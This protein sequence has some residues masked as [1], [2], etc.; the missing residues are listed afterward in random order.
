M[1]LKGRRAIGLRIL[2]AVKVGALI[3]QY[4]SSFLRVLKGRA[5]IRLDVGPND[6]GLRGLL[7]AFLLKEYYYHAFGE[8]QPDL[9]Y[10]NPEVV[11]AK[12]HCFACLS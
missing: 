1:A 12:L 2:E 8:F 11:E 3:F 7:R 10:R 5:R 4:L 9:N 6:Q